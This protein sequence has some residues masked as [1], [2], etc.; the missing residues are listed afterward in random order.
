MSVNQDE[1]LVFKTRICQVKKVSHFMD[2]NFSLL[3]NKVHRSYILPNDC[4]SDVQQVYNRYHTVLT[5]SEG[6]FLRDWRVM[7]INIVRSV[8]LNVTSIT[9]STIMVFKISVHNDFINYIYFHCTVVIQYINF[10]LTTKR[11]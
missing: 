4:V 7:V 2:L 5:T 8:R 10:N 3:Y 9:L 1:N 6:S 11:Q